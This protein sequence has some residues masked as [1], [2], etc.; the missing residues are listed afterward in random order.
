MV[1]NGIGGRT[2]AEAKQNLTAD[3]VTEWIK[4]RNK[5]GCLSVTRRFEHK[6]G[7]LIYEMMRAVGAKKEG[8]AAF[9]LSDFIDFEQFKSRDDEDSAPASMFDFV[10]QLNSGH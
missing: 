3:E 5:R 8:G 10:R 1:L 9:E 7:R 4:Y 2:I 6:I